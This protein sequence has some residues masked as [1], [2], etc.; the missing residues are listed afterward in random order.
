MNTFLNFL[1]NRKQFITEGFNSK[2][3]DKVIEIFEETILV[4]KARYIEG[5]LTYRKG[6]LRLKYED[7]NG[8]D[9][10]SFKKII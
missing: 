5:E 4:M 3:I 2:K 6:Y 7:E 10:F 9:K 1:E 8:R